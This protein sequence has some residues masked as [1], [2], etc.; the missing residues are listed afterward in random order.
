MADQFIYNMAD[1]WNNVATTFVAF[2][3]NVTDTASAAD[4][5]LIDMR[6]GGVPA[7][8]VDK[9]GNIVGNLF[10]GD[11]TGGD[12][13]GLAT[14][15]S[16]ADGGT[17]ATTLAAAKTAL[18]IPTAPG[19]YTS[20]EQTITLGATLNLSHG[21][22]GI[23]TIVHARLRCKTAEHGYTEDTEAMGEMMD[24]GLANSGLGFRVGATTIQARFG[25]GGIRVMDASGV[26]ATITPDRWRL[27]VTAMRWA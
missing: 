18:G 15:I 5:K 10:T 14:P 4:S 1:T 21:L 27:I 22:A 26:M 9:G 25:A 2:G 17:G 7:F 12:V 16:I 19:I 8:T 11:V 6:V 24:P 13:S 20:T 3:M 23:P